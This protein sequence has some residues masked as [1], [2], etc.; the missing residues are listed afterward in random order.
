MEESLKSIFLMIILHYDVVQQEKKHAGVLNNWYKSNKWKLDLYATCSYLNY[1]TTLTLLP[2]EG[3]GGKATMAIK[4]S[5]KRE[6]IEGIRTKK[7]AIFH[8]FTEALQSN[9]PPSDSCHVS[10]R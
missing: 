8:L 7:N 10:Q 5:C 1:K 2:E 6:A 9:G 4:D 3:D